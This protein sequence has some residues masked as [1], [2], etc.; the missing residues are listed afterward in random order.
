[1]TK[2]YRNNSWLLPAGMRVK[3]VVLKAG[4]QWK[5]GKSRLFNLL[6]RL[7]MSDVQAAL[8]QSVLGYGLENAMGLPGVRAVGCGAGLQQ[9]SG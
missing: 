3:Q 5:P 1:M 9:D 8:D 2:G 6:S 7:C 4:M